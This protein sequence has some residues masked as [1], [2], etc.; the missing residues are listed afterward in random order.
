VNPPDGFFGSAGHGA[1]EALVIL[2]SSYQCKLGR[3]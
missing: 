2:Y 1:N 3:T